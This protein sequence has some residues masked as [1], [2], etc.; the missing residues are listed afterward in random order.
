MSGRSID[1]YQAELAHEH[2]K[3][4]LPPPP[5]EV[6]GSLAAPD[7]V[8]SGVERPTLWRFKHIGLGGRNAALRD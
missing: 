1:W 5:L 6:Y 8:Q 7:N 2:K 4:R 3:G